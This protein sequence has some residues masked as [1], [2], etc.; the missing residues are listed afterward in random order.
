LSKPSRRATRG[1]VRPGD[2]SATSAGA[3]TPTGRTPATRAGRRERPRTGYADR[4]AWQRYRTVLL[5][6]VVI[7]GIGVIG[8]FAFNS[9]TAKAYTCATIF[10]PTPKPSPDPSST[11]DP[12]YVQS[13]MGNSHRVGS[14]QEY[15]SCPPASGNHY[16]QPRAPIEPRVYGPDDAVGPTEWVHNLEHGA[17][18]VLYRGQPGDPGLT[19]EVQRQ[20]RTYFGQI[21]PSP[22]CNLATGAGDGPVIAR[23]DEMATPFAALVWGRVLPLDTLDTQQINEFWLAKGERNNPEPFCSP[24]TPSPAPSGSAV[25]SASPAESP[26]AS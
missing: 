20:I 7:A 23:F 17:L 4:S 15:A 8:A 2:R 14:P 1:A 21:P 25:P 24:P 18:V 5:A 3:A 12:G 19:E 10:N 16:A 13:D 6:V 11:P 26:A 22:V 9:A